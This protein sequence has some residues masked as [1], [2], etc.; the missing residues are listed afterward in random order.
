MPDAA[1]PRAA[2]PAPRRRHRPPDH[3]LGH[4]GDAPPAAAGDGVRRRPALA[5]RR[6][7]RHDVRRR[8]RRA[9]GL[10][11]RRG[12]SRSSSSTAPT[13]SGERTVGVVCNPELTLPE[14]RDR[15]LD[16]GDEGCLSF[17]GAFVECA[18]PDLATVTGTGL[19]G[20]PVDLLRRRP[21]GPLPAARDRPHPR[22]RLRRPAPDQ[23]AQEA[24]EGARQG[25]RGVP[26]GLA[27]LLRA[28]RTAR[29]M[30]PR[31]AGD[32]RSPGA[33]PLRRTRR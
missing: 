30:G 3:P 24:A 1:R 19:D 31:P 16:D 7:G 21:A 9:G 14:G 22:H 28:D 33:A 4:A 20:E 10:P 8:R 13:T 6:H 32:V 29:R 2:R 27:R 18:R 17:P 15:Q 12:P 26:G 25:R 23:G 11:D 5:G